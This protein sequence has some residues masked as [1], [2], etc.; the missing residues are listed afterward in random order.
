[1]YVLQPRDPEC[2]MRQELIHTYNETIRLDGVIAVVHDEMARI[3]LIRRRYFVDITDQMLDRR[4]AAEA[5]SVT[6]PN[7]DMWVRK[8]Q[9]KGYGEGREML[10]MAADVQAFKVKRG[11]N[12]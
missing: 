5:L 1:M 11:E 2:Q 9:L 8:G 12:A 4:A 7:V 6:I 10:F 3:H